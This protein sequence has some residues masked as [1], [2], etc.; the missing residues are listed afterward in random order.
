MNKKWKK[1]ILVMFMVLVTVIYTYYFRTITDDELY[2]YGY[3]FNIVTGL[4]PYRDF[5]MIIP[6]LFSYLLAIFLRIFG[7]HL[8][9]YHFIIA[10]I[11]TFIFYICYQSIGKRAFVIY[12]L[13]LIY[14]Y[15]GYNMFALGLLFLLFNLGDEK[16][17]ILEPI[18][19][20]L[21][22]LTKQTLGLLIVPSLIYSKNRKKTAMIYLLFMLCFLLYLAWNETVLSFLDYC[23]FGMFDFA[24]K[25]S[26]SVNFLMIIEILIILGLSYFSFVTKRKDIFFCLMFQV[27]ALPIVNY[28]HFVISFIPVIYLILKEGK[29]NNY[30][31]LF[32]MVAVFSFFLSFSFVACGG[33][34]E[35]KY[36]EHYS[37]DNFMKGRVNYRI[38]ESYVLKAKEFIDEYDEYTPYIFGRFTYMMKLNYGIP[39]TKYD[40]INNGNMG[41]N[42][43]SRYIDEIDNYCQVNKCLFIINDYEEEISSTIQTNMDI[44]EYV[45]KNY[46]KQYSSNMFSVYINL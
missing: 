32:S 5:N 21:M 15:I 37:V 22:F 35:Y 40:N 10:V 26:T 33:K 28:M 39:I 13:L 24:S 42:G 3:G 29:E 41:Y 18:L 6:P 12:F 19:I 27:M 45:K 46:N 36:L 30:I 11:V 16:E 7:S 4:V 34:G 17:E 23:L 8:L 14:P 1:I 25:N 9:V 44:L 43:A 31:S 20:S 2:N 38:T